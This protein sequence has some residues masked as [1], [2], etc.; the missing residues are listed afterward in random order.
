MG[1]DFFCSRRSLPTGLPVAAASPQMP[2]TSSTAWNAMPSVIPKCSSAPTWA[3]LPPPSTA[4][5]AV[6][7]ASSAP[8]LFASMAMHS[9][10]V[11]VSPRSSA[12]SCAWPA[13]MAEV[14]LTRR[15]V[16]AA[17]WGVRSS[18]RSTSNA[19]ACMASP[20]T[21][22]SP[23]PNTSHTVARWRRVRSLSM[24]SSW[25]SEKLW[26]SSTATPPEIAAFGSPCTASVPSIARADRTP[27]PLPA[28]EGLPSWSVQPR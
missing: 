15:R 10:R 16:A 12:T 7:C 2:R 6:D 25:I 27:L 14:A 20:T 17:P 26:M 3:S 13:I 28:S 24:M 8:V 11:A 21:M 22:P 9:S 18:S 5:M 19:S 23:T 1:I 4:P